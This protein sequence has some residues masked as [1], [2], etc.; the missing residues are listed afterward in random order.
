M[1]LV[2][3]IVFAEDALQAFYDRGGIGSDHFWIF[4]KAFIGAAPAVIARDGDGGGERPVVAG[5]AKLCGCHFGDLL[6]QIRISH[7][8]EADI[9]RE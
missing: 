6:D 2:Q 5:D 4:C 8:A 1:G 7:G 3:K 9:V